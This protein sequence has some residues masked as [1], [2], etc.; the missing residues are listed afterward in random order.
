MASF[1][2]TEKELKER[3]GKDAK[4]FKL[5]QFQNGVELDIHEKYILSLILNYHFDTGCSQY[6]IHK[7][8]GKV[9]KVCLK[10]KLEKLVLKKYLSKDGDNYFIEQRHCKGIFKI[11]KNKSYNTYDKILYDE[12]FTLRQR[13][14]YSINWDKVT[15]IKKVCQIYDISLR[16]VRRYVKRHIRIVDQSEL[17]LY[18]HGEIMKTLKLIKVK[19][20]LTKN[21]TEVAISKQVDCTIT[22]K[23]NAISDSVCCTVINANNEKVIINK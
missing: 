10:K 5:S 17:N 23:E 20:P 16:N 9:S 19:W 22:N 11:S 12:N 1:L 14:I 18:E 15:S 6:L 4:Y 2:Y 8:L 21:T 3:F 7:S 13:I